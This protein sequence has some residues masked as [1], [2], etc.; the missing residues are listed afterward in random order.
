[1]IYVVWKEIAAQKDKKKDLKILNSQSVIGKESTIIKHSIS[2]H[3]LKK[4]WREFRSKTEVE[5]NKKHSFR[6]FG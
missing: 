4:K 1:M 2:F 5:M 3:M 6:K